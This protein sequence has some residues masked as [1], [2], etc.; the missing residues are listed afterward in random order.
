MNLSDIRTRI[1]A[2]LDWGPKQSAEA[3]SRVNGFINRAYNDL[4]LEAPFLFFEDTVQLYAQKDFVPSETGDTVRVFDCGD[5]TTEDL[6]TL[7]RDLTFQP[8]TNATYQAQWNNHRWEV[9]GTW[10]ARWIEIKDPVTNKYHTHQIREIW[11]EGNGSSGSPYIQYMTLATPWHASEVDPTDGASGSPLYINME[12]RIFT[13][14][15]Y[16]PDDLVELNSARVRSGSRHFPLKVITQAAAEEYSVA[17]EHR[18]STSGLP[19]TMYRRGYFQ[20]PAPT[21][22]PTL[23]EKPDDNNNAHNW[24]GPWPIGTYEYCYTW[25]W[26]NRA[27]R[28]VHPTPY[29]TTQTIVRGSSDPGGTGNTGITYQNLVPLFESAPSPTAEITIAK[30]S[31]IGPGYITISFPDVDFINGF[32]DPTSATAFTRENR[33]GWYVQ[34]YRRL[35]TIDAAT[36]GVGHSGSG[37]MNY[38]PTSAQAGESFH[39]LQQLKLHQLNDAMVDNGTTNPQMHRRLRDTHGYQGVGLYPIPDDEYVIDIRCTRR[40]EELKEDTDVPRLP[41]ETCSLLINRAIT[42]LYEAQ[43]NYDAAVY[44]ARNAE[45]QLLNLKKRYGE[46]MPAEIPSQKRLARAKP[47]LGRRTM[48]RKWYTL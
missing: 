9:D 15:Y 28:D 5:D 29:D 42:L 21:T 33:S 26:G 7:K 13:K 10:N 46:L 40:P 6:W 18:L 43:G 1:F 25:C 22:A 4:A 48:L 44:A 39:L 38:A 14:Q 27:D 16:L 31:T 30:A 45:R 12:Y 19:S 3:K 35:K 37:T 17:T 20:L 24:L 41:A 2:Q 47:G 23:T 11:T 8:E 34:V 36:S 32:G